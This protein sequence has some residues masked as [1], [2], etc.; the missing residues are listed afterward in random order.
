MARLYISVGH[1]CKSMQVFSVFRAKMADIP[2][3]QC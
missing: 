2:A 1:L 3:A